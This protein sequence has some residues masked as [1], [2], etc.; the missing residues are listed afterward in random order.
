MEKVIQ[1]KRRDTEKGAL[2]TAQDGID[3]VSAAQDQALGILDIISAQEKQLKA[4]GRM[5]PGL[6]EELNAKKLN[7]LEIRDGYTSMITGD[8]SVPEYFS[9]NEVFERADKTL[10]L[11]VKM[12]MPMTARAMQNM[13]GNNGSNS[14]LSSDIVFSL[15]DPESSNIKVWERIAST[16]P[17][18]R[19]ALQIREQEFQKI[20][21]WINGNISI[22]RLV[23]MGVIN[24]AVQQMLAL[25][26]IK[27]PQRTGEETISSID[28]QK[29]TLS[30]LPNN[31]KGN[32]DKLAI[33]SQSF[34]DG[35]SKATSNGKRSEYLSFH[36]DMFEEH[37]SELSAFLKKKTGFQ[38]LVT[39]DGR[40]SIPQLRPEAV[41]IPGFSERPNETISKVAQVFAS[42]SDQLIKAGVITPQDLINALNPD[43]KPAT[44]EALVGVDAFTGAAIKARK[45]EE[46]GEAGAEQ[47]KVRIRRYN[48]ETRSFEEVEE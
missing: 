36:K 33:L 45:V 10:N 3:I 38:M 17:L 32:G 19:S 43:Q 9:T 2:F 13:A 16:D 23:G 11:F 31:A 30:P 44:P 6:R 48:P 40:I 20:G 4:T 25:S 18:G 29:A 28:I 21:A 24:P 12:N 8:K 5:T 39:G 26:T 47:G 34:E 46:D 1:T 14:A 35:L 7:I 37:V 22:D 42:Y 41:G 15:F 27:R